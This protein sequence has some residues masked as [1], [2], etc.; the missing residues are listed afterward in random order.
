MNFEI[1]NEITFNT[2]GAQ[3]VT[4]S[5]NQITDSYDYHESGSRIEFRNERVAFE[6]FQFHRR[7]FHQEVCTERIS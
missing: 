7:L 4:P 6:V 1:A 3:S 2:F 5:V